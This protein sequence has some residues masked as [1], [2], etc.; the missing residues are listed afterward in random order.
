MKLEVKNITKSFDGKEIL[1]GISFS[2]E[3]GKDR[4]ERARVLHYK[5]DAGKT[6]GMFDEKYKQN[7][8]DC[9]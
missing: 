1:K 3:S 9:S 5:A 6:G 4:D 2:V 8:M 7:D